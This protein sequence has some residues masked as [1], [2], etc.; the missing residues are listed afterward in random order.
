MT[1]QVQLGKLFKFSRKYEDLESD[2][3]DRSRDDVQTP[4]EKR[5]K[6]E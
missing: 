6:V 4:N 3:N 1:R 2:S 5:Q